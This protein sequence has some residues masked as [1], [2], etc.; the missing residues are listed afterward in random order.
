VTIMGIHRNSPNYSI[1]LSKMES[2]DIKWEDGWGSVAGQREDK[3][4][5]VIKQSEIKDEGP[6]GFTWSKERQGCSA[7]LVIMIQDEISAE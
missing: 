4:K 5:T 3:C 6:L 7:Y 2:K 1:I